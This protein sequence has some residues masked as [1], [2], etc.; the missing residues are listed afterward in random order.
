MLPKSKKARLWTMGTLLVIAITLIFFIK[1]TTVKVILGG[2][3][4]AL[5]VGLG[6]EAK[7]TDYDLGTAIQTGSLKKAKLKRNEEGNLINIVEFCSQDEIDYNCS[8]FKTQVEAMEVYNK[9]KDA[10]KNM[11]VYGL[12]RDKDGKV[13]ES[14]P[15]GKS[16]G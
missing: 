15:L 9:C 5:L 2:V 13:C 7:D 16:A 11:D 14:L 4:V 1:N 8:D 6:F 12:D 10:G 3:I